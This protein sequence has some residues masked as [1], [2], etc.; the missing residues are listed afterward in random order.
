MLTGSLRPKKCWVSSFSTSHHLRRLKRD[1]DVDRLLDTARRN[2]KRL[3]KISNNMIS[4]FGPILEFDR[5]LFFYS[6]NFRFTSASSSRGECCCSI[7]RTLTTTATT[8]TASLEA[9]HIITTKN[10]NHKKEQQQMLRSG[11][12]SCGMRSHKTRFQKVNLLKVLLFFPISFFP[13]PF[14]HISRLTL[15]V[16]RF[17]QR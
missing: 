8:T 16:L 6:S 7:D 5:K 2:W 10:R 17:K 12:G 15:W 11:M 3:F 9:R 1:D 13:L 14:M 4:T